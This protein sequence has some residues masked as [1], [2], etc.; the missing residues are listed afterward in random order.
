MK[1]LLQAFQNGELS[2]F[3]LVN[4]KICDVK[5]VKPDTYDLILDIKGKEYVWTLIFNL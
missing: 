4:A 2:V 1:R 5:Q 3:D